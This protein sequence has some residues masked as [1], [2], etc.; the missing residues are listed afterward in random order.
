MPSTVSPA[1]QGLLDQAL[2]EAH[3]LYPHLAEAA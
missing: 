3:P 1:R 2:A